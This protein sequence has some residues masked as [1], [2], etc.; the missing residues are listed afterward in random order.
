MYKRC[1]IVKIAGEGALSAGD[2]LKVDAYAVV[3]DVLGH[4]ETGAGGL[5]NIEAV[6]VH[7]RQQKGDIVILVERAQIHIIICP[8]GRAKQH[9]NEHCQNN[10]NA[11]SFHCVSNLSK[12]E[13]RSVIVINQKNAYL[14][15]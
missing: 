1:I 4:A 10:G 3:M 12:T 5:G 13:R 2:A 11:E 14:S 15:T 9:Y 6:P 7:H 8:R